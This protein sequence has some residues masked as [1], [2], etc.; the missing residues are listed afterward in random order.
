PVNVRTV[1]FSLA[2]SL[3]T[4]VGGFT[5]YIATWL[6]TV[7]HDKAAPGWWM[8]F[9]ASCGLIATLILYQRKNKAPAT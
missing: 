3:A 5:P 7:T 9:A 8:T 1:G 4:T 2:Y 6:I